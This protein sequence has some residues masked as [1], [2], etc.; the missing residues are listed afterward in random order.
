[1]KKEYIKIKVSD[2]VPY[3]RNPRKITQD[4]INVVKESIIQCGNLDPI[5]IDEDNVILSGH[6]RRLALHE[7]GIEETD[8]VRY[9]GMT[10]EQK[11][12]YR[13]LANKTG[14]FS[15]WDYELLDWELEDLNF[16]G[17][18]FG[19]TMPENNDSTTVDAVEDNYNAELPTEPKTK[20][21]QIWKLGQHRLMCGDSTN[22]DDVALLMDGAKA[23]IAFCSP[24]YGAGNSARLRKHYEPGMER[25]HSYYKSHDDDVDSWDELLTKSTDIML[26]NATQCFINVQMLADNKN[27]LIDWLHR[28][29]DHL[30]DIIV[31]EKKIAAPQMHD[32]ILNNKFEFIF[33]LSNSD[34]TRKI[35]YGSFHGNKANIVCVD[36]EQN[37]YSDV[38]HAVFPVGLPT[39]ILDINSKA[40]TC[41]DMFGGT[42]TTMIACEQMGVSCYMNELEPAYCDIIIDRWEQFTGETAEL[43]YG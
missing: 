19:F 14:E 2:L 25:L 33:V 29:N 39:E 31:W 27:I 28:H 12:K 41:L 18:D 35:K 9:T 11:K 8:A 16:E 32:N 30:C 20:R 21:G 7:L 22:A 17:F 15:A 10:E 24:P 36:H 38:H 34:A 43:I 13:L 1:M 3:E 42:G 23:D 5:E 26:A 37:E 40:R 4:A 6:T